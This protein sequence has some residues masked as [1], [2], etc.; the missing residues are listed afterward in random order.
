MFFFLY[1]VVTIILSGFQLLHIMIV[2]VILSLADAKTTPCISFPHSICMKTRINVHHVFSLFFSH[3][4]RIVWGVALK[5]ISFCHNRDY[6][7]IMWSCYMLGKKVGRRLLGYKMY[8]IYSC[9]FLVYMLWLSSL[10]FFSS[11]FCSDI[12]TLNCCCV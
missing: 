4:V 10:T 3:F 9:C 5:M 7:Y 8:S 2:H 11:G 1:K 6:Y 12:Q